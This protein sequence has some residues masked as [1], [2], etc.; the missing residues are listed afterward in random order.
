MKHLA[1]DIFWGDIDAI[2]GIVPFKLLNEDEVINMIDY[3]IINIFKG[4]NLGFVDLAAKEDETLLHAKKTIEGYYEQDINFYST[5]TLIHDYLNTMQK[6]R[7]TKGNLNL[8]KLRLNTSQ[9][10][11]IKNAYDKE[12]YGTKIKDIF[13]KPKTPKY[14]IVMGKDIDN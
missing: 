6:F 8:D 7:L 5:K 4:H 14:E 12:M 9:I 11:S 1:N 13:P 2:T 10:M 3:T